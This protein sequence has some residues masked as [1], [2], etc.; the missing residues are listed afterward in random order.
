MLFQ[1]HKKVLQMKFQSY[2]VALIVSLSIFSVPTTG[3]AQTESVQEVSQAAL[4]SLI[5]D[6][7]LQIILLQNQL[8]L[9]SEQSGAEGTASGLHTVFENNNSVVAKYFVTDVTDVDRIQNA[10]HRDYFLRVVDVMPKEYVAK[11][12]QFMVFNGADTTFAAYVETVAPQ[13]ETWQYAIH[14][15]MLAWPNSVDNTEL[16]VHELAHIISYEEVIGI[17]KPATQKCDEYFAT[18]GCPLANSYLSQFVKYFWTDVDLDRA[19]RFTNANSFDEI[20]LYYDN[21]KT[22][23]VT[24]YAASSPEEDFAETFTYFMLDLPVSG[25]GAQNKHDFFESYKELEDIK[26]VI[27]QEV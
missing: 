11:I 2:F 5:E 4:L 26:R 8:Y 14:Q 12:S 21:N 10:S 18:F 13:H 19:L 16:I 1:L 9:M 24:E 15:D 7:Q 27:Q 20:S 23:Y 22:K 3:F 25:E 17:P 6:L